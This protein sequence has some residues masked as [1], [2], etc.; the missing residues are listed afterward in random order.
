MNIRCKEYKVNNF[1][2]PLDKVQSPLSILVS[3]AT[4]SFIFMVISVRGT[5]LKV[6]LWNK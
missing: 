2:F 3:K 6:A 5:R 4:Y 1:F